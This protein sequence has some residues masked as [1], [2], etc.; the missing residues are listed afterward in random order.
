MESELALSLLFC[1][2]R[3]LTLGCT[4]CQPLLGLTD[5]LPIVTSGEKVVA[6]VFRQGMFPFFAVNDSAMVACT[7]NKES[8]NWATSSFRASTTLFSYSICCW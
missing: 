3:L 4:V 1:C 8:F 5:L 6:A 2:R 7:D